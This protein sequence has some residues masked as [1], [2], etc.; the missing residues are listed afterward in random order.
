MTTLHRVAAAALVGIAVSAAFAGCMGV[1]RSEPITGPIAFNDP[2]LQR[3]RAAFERFCYRCHT[4][5]EGGMGPIINDK[6][7]PRFLM[8]FQVRHGLGV[9]PKF[10]PETIPDEQLDEIV[11]YIVALR[12]Q[13]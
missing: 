3:G 2:H 8:K 13:R 11:D 10:P 12:H 9:M 1:R 5:G 4:E 7:L 6:P